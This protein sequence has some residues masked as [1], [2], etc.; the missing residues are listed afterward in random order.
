MGT[1]TA[2]V[3]AYVVVEEGLK[4]IA[5]GANHLFLKKGINR[6][7]EFLIAQSNNYS[8]P[9]EC[10]KHI[11]DVS[12]ISAGDKSISSLICKGIDMVGRNGIIFVEEGNTVTDE[13]EIVEGLRFDQGFVSGY[14]VTDKERLEVILQDAY[15]LLTDKKITLVKNELIPVLDLVLKKKTFI[16]NKRRIW[17][18]SSINS[19]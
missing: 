12:L 2:I 17:S 10:M 4:N 16:N 19:Y 3:I 5:F 18:R 8:R 1:T 6:S 13:I 11:S 14:F 7:L 15:I 9:V